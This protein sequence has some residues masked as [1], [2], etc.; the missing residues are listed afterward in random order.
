MIAKASAAPS[1]VRTQNPIS[2]ITDRVGF[3]LP[4]ATGGARQEW[5]KFVAQTRVLVV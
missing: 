4:P 1:A 5:P 3:T 2:E